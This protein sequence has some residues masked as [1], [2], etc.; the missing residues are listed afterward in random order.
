LP[1]EH[2]NVGLSLLGGAVLQVV[3]GLG[4]ERHHA[5]LGTELL[6]DLRARAQ[7]R[8]RRSDRVQVLHQQDAGIRVQVHLVVPSRARRRD[9]RRSERG[10]VG[11]GAV[12]RPM[13]A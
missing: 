2:L 13:G 5:H 11:P 1:V 7:V 3:I 6:Q 12:T 4:R 9:H 8:E 10:P